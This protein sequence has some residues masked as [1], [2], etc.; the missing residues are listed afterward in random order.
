MPFSKKSFSHLHNQIETKVF[1]KLLD[2]A[3]GDG[4][5]N[6]LL[7]TL[8]KEGKGFDLIAYM[9]SLFFLSEILDDGYVKQGHLNNLALE[10]S[11][12][13][14]FNTDD[15]EIN[16]DLGNGA[17]L[18]NQTI[19]IL[20][21]C[22]DGERYGAIKRLMG[23]HNLSSNQFMFKDKQ[24]N[25]IIP[26][27]ITVLLNKRLLPA[28]N[29]PASIMFTL[30]PLNK[31]FTTVITPA[32]VAGIAMDGDL[33]NTQAF[34]V[35]PNIL[36]NQLHQDGLLDDVLKQSSEEDV[37][38]SLRWDSSMAL[39]LL[40]HRYQIQINDDYINRVQAMDHK[41]KTMYQTHGSVVLEY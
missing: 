15:K 16:Q 13:R 23:F 38:S 9:D 41:I 35:H 24:V 25:V 11:C 36:Y 1:V 2:K 5:N 40:K 27:E 22:M 31:A 3:I 30:E 34:V 10:D 29:I 37:K 26:F 4:L 6:P 19:A 28:D 12:V 32:P 20:N 21:L 8:A 33:S 7:L 18:A 39:K 14:Y 17:L